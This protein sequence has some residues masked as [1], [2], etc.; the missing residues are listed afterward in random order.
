M[1]VT[2]TLFSVQRVRLR[3]F[4]SGKEPSTISAHANSELEVDADWFSSEGETFKPVAHRSEIHHSQQSRQDYGVWQA[5][6][7]FKINPG[8]SHWPSLRHWRR[9]RS[10]NR[11]RCEV[12]HR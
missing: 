3:V 11:N 10:E 6:D 12:P 7:H 8:L 2:E 1:K 5:L 9:Q 4:L